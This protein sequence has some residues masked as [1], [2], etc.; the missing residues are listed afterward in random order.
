AGL[1]HVADQEP[2]PAGF[3]RLAGQALQKIDQ[4]GMSPVAIAREPHHLPR[5]AVDRQRRRSGKATLRIEADAACLDVRGTFL[6]SENLFGE[7]L[8]AF[9]MTNRRQRLGVERADVLSESRIARQEG[10]SGRTA[11]AG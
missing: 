7:S 10:E 2:G 11:D 3:R 5:A 4:L 1:R 9:G 6:S 8:R